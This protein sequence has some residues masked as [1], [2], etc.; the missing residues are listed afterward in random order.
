MIYP[1]NIEEKIGFAPIRDAVKKLCISPLGTGLVDS[2]NFSTSFNEITHSIDC[3]A[4]MKQILQSDNPVPID[5]LSDATPILNSIIPAGTSLPP[6]DLLSVRSMLTTMALI[7][8]YFE[9]LR[10]TDSD[11]QSSATPYPDLDSHV[12]QLTPFPALVSA[13]DR[14][15]DKYGNVKDNASP[16]LS[17]IRSD[18][19]AST[20]TVN[21]I[22]RRVIARAISDGL[23]EHDTTPAIRDGRLVLPVAPMNKRRIS[24]IVHDESASGKTIFIEPAEIVEANNRIRQLEMDERREIARIMTSIAAEIRPSI[25]AILESAAILALFDFIRAKAMYAI[26]TDGERPAVASETDLEWYHACHPVL[27]LSLQ[28]QQKEIIPLDITLTPNA[29]LLIIS[30]PNA[31]GK[32][33]CLKTVGTLQYMLQCGMLP[34]VYSNS[35]FGIFDDIFVDIGDDQSIEDDLSTYSSHLRNMKLMLR[36]GNPSSLLLIDE[37]GGGTE[38]QI[39]GAIAQ[40]ILDYFNNQKM[41]G[42]VTTHYQNLKQFAEDTDGMING[43]MLYDRHLMQ[44][45]FKLSIGNPGSSFAIEI[46]RKIGLPATIIDAAS[47]IVGSDYINL[48]KYLLDIARDK[49]YWENKRNAIKLKEKKLETILE[50]Y[51]TEAETLRQNRREIIDDARQ[52]AEKIIAQSNAS[53]ERTIHD[54]KRAQAEREKT[55]EARRKLKEKQTRLTSETTDIA[56]RHPLLNKAPKKRSKKAAASSAVTA[57]TTLRP[58]MNVR[59][60]GEGTVGTITEIQGDK[61]TVT[62]GMIKTTVQSSRLTPTIAKPDTGARKSSFL[63]SATTDAIRNRQLRFKQEIDVRGMRVD[64]AIQAIT[65]FIDDAMQF[66]SS[67]VRILHGTGTG[68]LR[69]SIRQYLASVPGITRVHDE[70]IRL[71]GAGITV[72]EFD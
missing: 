7:A 38:P 69:Q 5:Q 47:Q 33:V 41:W 66:E 39:G 19:R 63:T 20:G 18:L 14:I 30:G 35:R 26:Q 50:K 71:G 28:R 25:P 43:S 27:K 17:Q 13:I 36:H 52:Q 55:L 11:D 4:Q 67:R 40:A 34:P 6:H 51:Q 31:G 42:V 8:Q 48:D 9:K 58:G 60:D 29:R 61:A 24:G 72:V 70:D 10:D 32:S 62:F 65:Y 44:P 15:I 1:S 56:N 22:M 64:E 37:F 45:L 53:I 2:M 68:A 54:I 59:L 12:R 21:S 57:D 49:R 3:V 46:A 16:L 23:V